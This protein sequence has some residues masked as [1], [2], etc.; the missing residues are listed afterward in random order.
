VNHLGYYAGIFWGFFSLRE[1]DSG[2]R[3]LARSK[4]IKDAEG[5]RRAEARVLSGAICSTASL[6]YIAG[7]VCDTVASTGFAS[8]AFNVASGF[9][10]V[11]SLL[12][13]SSA[14][15][16]ALRCYRFNDRLNEYLNHPNLTGVER[17]QGALQF[18]K[19]AVYV[20]TE[21]RA[22][23]VEQIEKNHPHLSPNEKSQLL[24]QKIADLT[25]IKVKYL[26]RRTSNKSLLLI[27]NQAD[28]ILA[29][30]ADPKTRAEGIKEATIM[31]HTI[32]NE[33]KAKMALFILGFIAALIS[34]VAMLVSTFLSAGSLP[35]FLYGVAGTIYLG[36]TVYNN[37]GIVLKKDVDSKAID[38][39]PIQDLMPHVERSGF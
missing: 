30:L 14:A 2:Y 15:L 23:L 8:V 26:K 32:Q 31:L 17:L 5:Q 13:M 9:F 6:A 18:L 34:F 12:A 21:E 20:T 7:R 28:A 19:E 39:H 3:D 36:M 10:G 29:K 38:L 27:L 25:E 4:Q 22:E 33:N 24:E 11:G 16:G 1:L 35:F 37:A